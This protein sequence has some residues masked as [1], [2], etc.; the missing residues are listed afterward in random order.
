MYATMWM[1]LENTKLSE[2]S[3]TQKFTYCMI[4]F[5]TKNSEQVNPQRQRAEQWLTEAGGDCRVSSQ[6]VWV[7]F[8]VD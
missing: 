1:N 8:R 3:Q 2:R 5:I 7:Y 6:W 4:P